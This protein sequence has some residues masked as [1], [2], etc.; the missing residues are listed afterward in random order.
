MISAVHPAIQRLR[1]SRA[2]AAA[3]RGCY[4]VRGDGCRGPVARR[5]GSSSENHSGRSAWDYLKQGARSVNRV[6]AWHIKAASAHT[7]QLM[8]VQVLGARITLATALVCA[9]ELAI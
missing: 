8:P 4:D 6:F 5:S 3:N 2:F 7:I 1:T 9:F